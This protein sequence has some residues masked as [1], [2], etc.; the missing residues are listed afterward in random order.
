MLSGAVTADRLLS[1]ILRHDRKQ[2]SY[3][4]AL[5][6]ALNDAALTYPDLVVHG[7]DVAVPLRVLAT[8]WLAYYWAFLDPGA[9]VFQ[10]Q[11]RTISGDRRAN[12][13]EFRPALTLVREAWLRL[14]GSVQSADGFVLAGDMAVTRRRATY[15]AELTQAFDVA[16]R[17]TVPA[18]AQ[19]IRYAG[20]GEW[21]VFPPP[22][23]WRELQDSG[24]VPVPGT[25]VEEVCVVVRADIWRVLVEHSLW[26]EALTIHQWALFTESFTNGRYSPN[27]STKA[28]GA[29][30]GAVMR[31]PCSPI[32]PGTDGH[33]RGSVIASTCWYW[34]AASSR[35]R[36]QGVDWISRAPTISI[37]SCH[38]RSTR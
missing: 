38:W 27:Q 21:Q 7:R 23:Q 30:C 35:V 24:A 5:V 33:S 17:A 18:L 25:R 14:V 4:L 32:D 34:R 37:T 31:T 16:V 6:R 15:P 28:A 1:S 29:R 22:R 12:D 2:N 8:S 11:R 13:V 19:P 26:I 3:K 10:G 9:P 20:P 36:G